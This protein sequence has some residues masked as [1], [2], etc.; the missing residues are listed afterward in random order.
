M[1]DSFADI[2]PTVDVTLV[3]LIEV[4]VVEEIFSGGDCKIMRTDKARKI[5]VK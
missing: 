4:G 3:E 5:P 2:W 1:H